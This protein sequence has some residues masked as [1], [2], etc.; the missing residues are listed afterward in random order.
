MYKNHKFSSAESDMRDIVKDKKANSG[1]K[2]RIK[3]MLNI[4]DDLEESK[5]Q[6]SSKNNNSVEVSEK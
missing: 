1:I 6:E 4:E 2:N 3:T 5:S